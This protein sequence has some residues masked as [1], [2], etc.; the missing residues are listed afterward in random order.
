[1]YEPVPRQPLA[2]QVLRSLMRQIAARNLG[3]GDR[4]PAERD[5]AAEL[6]VS[7]CTVR[8]ALRS[9]EAIG[10]VVRRPKRGAVLAPVDFA[11]VA[12]ISQVLML[13]SPA[14]LR[15]LLATRQLLEL[16]LLPLA[17][18]QARPADFEA[19]EAANRQSEA[20]LAAGW[21]PIDGDLAFHRALLEASHNRFVFQ[22]GMLLDEFFRNVQPRLRIHPDQS[23]RTLDEHRKI[24]A[25]LRCGDFRKA[26]R[27]MAKHLEQYAQMPAVRAAG[28]GRAA[29]RK[30]KPS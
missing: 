12:E 3:V 24:I 18:Q 2:Q 15:E 20:E 19:M 23:R 26:Q 22:F 16:G 30:E 1:M 25:A 27:I 9:L 5:L 10:A 6:G 28:R 21:L 7:R 4:L 29:S 13:R 17:A 14:D 8:E 11:L